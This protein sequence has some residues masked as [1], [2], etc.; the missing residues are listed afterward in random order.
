MQTYMDII[1]LA[2]VSLILIFKLMSILGRKDHNRPVFKVDI[3]ES[4]QVEPTVVIDKNSS[5][6]DQ[7][8]IIDPSYNEDN[9]LEHSKSAFKMILEG[10]AQGKTYILS[11]LVDINTMRTFAY[12]IAKREENKQTCEINILKINDASVENVKLENNIA[13]ITVKFSA[14]VIMYI[15]DQNMHLLHGHINKI[16]TFKDNWVFKRN[17]KAPDPTWKLINLHNTPFIFT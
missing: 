3:K 4:D 5:P 7:L 12:A 1:F 15:Q 13:E 6:V 16:E 2:I 17:L 9:F 11:D 10:Y 14:E 8:K